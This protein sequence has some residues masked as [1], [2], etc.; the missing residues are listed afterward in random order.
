MSQHEEERAKRYC[1]VCGH[2]MGQM[3]RICDVCGSIMRPAKAGG[4][5]TAPE[6]HAS[7]ERCG[8]EIPYGKQHCT[9]CSAYLKERHQAQAA[10]G[11][12]KKSFARWLKS[13]FSRG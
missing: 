8:V 7:C 5:L 11:G 12:R 6:K 2:P 1:M 13:L 9:D 4:Q 3:Q 10:E